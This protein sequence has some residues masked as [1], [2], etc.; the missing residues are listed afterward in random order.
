MPA[1]RF[2][3]WWG[4]RSEL[5]LTFRAEMITRYATAYGKASKKDKDRVL[6]QVVAVIGR[7]RDNARR[8]Q[9]PAANLPPVRADRK[10]SDANGETSQWPPFA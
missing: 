1:K 5:S 2:S 7:S 10:R 6:D 8:R 9:V 3:A 4:M